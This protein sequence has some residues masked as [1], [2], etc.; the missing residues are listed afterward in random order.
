MKEICNGPSKVTLLIIVNY[1]NV[2][3]C[4]TGVKVSENLENFW[5]VFNNSNLPLF[6]PPL[7]AT[8][9]TTKAI[10]PSVKTHQ[11]ITSKT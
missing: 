6:R 7:S 9:P 4:I 11:K 5:Q 3:V 8:M 1:L 2:V 10:Q